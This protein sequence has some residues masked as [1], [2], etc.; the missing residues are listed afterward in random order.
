MGFEFLDSL[1]KDFLNLDNDLYEDLEQYPLIEEAKHNALINFYAKVG[2]L[3]EEKEETIIKLFMAAYN[4]NPID[5]LKLLFYTRDKEFGLGE[6]RIFRVIIKELG[7]INSED[8]R[9]NIKLIPV[10]GR[11]DDLYSLFDT[12][13][14]GDAI[15]LMRKQIGV[16]LKSKVPSTL[17]KWLK[18][19][20]A[21]SKETK[22]L[23]TETR[24]AFDLTSKEYRVLLSHLRQRVNIVETSMRKGEWDSIKYGDLSSSAIHKYYKAFYKHDNDRYSNYIKVSRKEK[25]NKNP[26]E[27]N[28]ELYPYELLRELILD[29]DKASDIDKR[30]AD[31]IKNNDNNKFNTLVCNGLSKK[32]LYNKNKGV[33]YLGA[34]ST[35]LFFVLKNTGKF[36]D[37]ILTVNPKP[38][39]KRISSNSTIKKVKEIAA[40]SS[41][42]IIN[43][44]EV[45]DVILYAGIKHQL[46]QED[47]PKQILFIVDE[48]CVLSYSANKNK[49][50]HENFFSK[51]DF[52]NLKE[53]W[54]MIGFDIPEICIWKMERESKASRII[55]DNNGLK[56]AYDY[57]NDTF[58]TIVNCETIYSKVLVDNVLSNIRYSL[59]K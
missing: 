4:E 28:K 8:L 18:S 40:A 1:K 42:E 52:K 19:E 16:D 47:M 34:I 2:F 14:Q 36:K 59:I 53:K 6:R 48:N 46:K 50:T 44:E 22:R 30:L 37:Y 3:R 45:L 11:W 17:S 49:D 20:N 9:R 31:F 13:L 26:K 10:Y 51:L 54:K 12:E 33:S 39:L 41:T 15:T 38:N 43:V 21:S 57:S 7:K 58:K 32:N 5:A 25:I 35:A 55:V 29:K 23:A 24:L 27:E 56:Y